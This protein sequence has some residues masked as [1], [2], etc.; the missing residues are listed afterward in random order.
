MPKINR[1]NPY[2]S[3]RVGVRERDRIRGAIREWW[4]Q[5]ARTGRLLSPGVHV[6]GEDYHGP[7]HWPDEVSLTAIHREFVTKTGVSVPKH[8]ISS[9][10]RALHVILSS[11]HRTYTINKPNGKPFLRTS[12]VFYKLPKPYT[13]ILDSNPS[14]MI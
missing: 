10:L 11:K 5:C 14:D 7:E 1:R 4:G 3:E 2:S 13:D 9:E 8:K 6:S 12:S